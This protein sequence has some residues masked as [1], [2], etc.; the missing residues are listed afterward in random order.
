MK[1]IPYM[2]SKRKLL[3]FIESSMLDYLNDTQIHSFFDAFAGS[4]RVA[5]HFRNDY[6]IVANDRQ[7]YT[8]VILEAYLQN[9][10]DPQYYLGAISHLNSLPDTHWSKT[11]G[12]YAN[13]YG[14]P[15][16]NGCSI[17][18]DGNPKPW[19]DYNARKIDSI[20]YEIDKMLSL[21]HI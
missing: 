3:G 13:T 12:W 19:V 1:T 15:E 18:A 17:G 21:I 20:R 8:K 10:K 16:N 9:T 2:G 5:H 11:D 6:K 14:A 7:S 4:G